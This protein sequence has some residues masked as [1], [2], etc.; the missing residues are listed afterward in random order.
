MEPRRG[1]L[2]EVIT[3]KISRVPV[4]PVDGRIPRLQQGTAIVNSRGVPGTLACLAHTLHDRQAVLLSNWHVLFGNGACEDDAVWLV[5]EFTRKRRYSALGRT[6]YGKV[7]VVRFGR[8]QHYIDCAVASCACTAPNGHV[9][10]ATTARVPFVEGHET[11]QVGT[12]VTKTG[13][14]TGTT[15]GIILDTN[16]SETL[17]DQAYSA[18][19]QILIRP[20]DGRPAFS[21]EGDSGSLLLNDSN[22]AVGLL[23]GTNTRGEGIACPI[24][25]VLYAMNIT[26]ARPSTL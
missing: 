9:L 10:G 20:I 17:D 5:S 16:Y 21:S 1:H 7:G 4:D 6:L 18:P 24:A 22:K 15:T 14:A 19:A 13:A 3:D 23:W 25:P 26:L 12:L 2:R 8:E 11:P